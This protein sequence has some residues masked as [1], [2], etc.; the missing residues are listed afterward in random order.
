MQ[1]KMIDFGRAKKYCDPKTGIHDPFR[2]NVP[3][4][5]A[6]Y[7]ASINAH[8]G[9]AL[10]R[11]DDLISLGYFLIYFL[12]EANLPWPVLSSSSS[13][14]SVHHTPDHLVLV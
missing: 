6:P 3:F 9:V 10:S 8:R 2:E 7:F 11:R 4:A 12:K 14:S 5:G 13:S 1:V